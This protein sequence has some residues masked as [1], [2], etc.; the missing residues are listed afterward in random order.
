LPGDHI[1]SSKMSN[2][3]NT[4]GCVA[5]IQRVVNH[6][7]EAR[8]TGLRFSTQQI[9]CANQNVCATQSSGGQPKLVNERSRRK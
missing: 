1:K 2:V 3:P 5:V 9:P 7:R 6:C 8:R 4:F